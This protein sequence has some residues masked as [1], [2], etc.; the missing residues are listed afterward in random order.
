M[1]TTIYR[2]DWSSASFA[3]P[4]SYKSVNRGGA[5][6]QNPD[7]P[8]FQAG[9]N[10]KTSVA[11][12]APAPDSATIVDKNASD[13]SSCGIV[14]LEVGGEANGYY[15]STVETTHEWDQY[16]S[17]TALND[18]SVCPVALEV[19]RFSTI[20]GPLFDPEAGLFTGDAF[21]SIY[22]SQDAGAN[23]TWEMYWIA[24]GAG[25][26]QTSATDVADNAWHKL[27]LVWKP[28]T[29]SGAQVGNYFPRNADGYLYFYVDDVAVYSH[30]GIALD[31]Q[32]NSLIGAAN[33]GYGFWHGYAGLLGPIGDTHLYQAGG[34]ST[35]L[36]E[37]VLVS[38]VPTVCC[39]PTEVNKESSAGPIEPVVDPTW[40]PSC[41]GGGTVPTAADL[42]DPES[43]IS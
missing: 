32:A 40:Y 30:A 24:G 21:I 20:P 31:I 37:T 42:I 41:T 1:P 5:D 38:S 35:S 8:E 9:E 3:Y 17:S 10:V 18:S 23:F 27:K 25:Q 43:W 28:G 16:F 14:L 7:F 15:D 12:P 34:S 33:K 36:P 22:A 6:T 19:T 11:S 4:T 29:V 2:P 39:E 26:S 13:Y